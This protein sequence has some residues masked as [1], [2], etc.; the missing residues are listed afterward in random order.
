MTVAEKRLLP[1]AHDLC[2]GAATD[3]VA[4]YFIARR[5]SDGAEPIAAAMK[6]RKERHGKSRK[7]AR[8]A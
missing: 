8:A 7:A 4:L 3:V 6:H 5:S 1:M 2:Q